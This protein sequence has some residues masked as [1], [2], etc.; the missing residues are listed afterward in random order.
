MAD[1]NEA[2][3]TEVAIIQEA[4]LDR[5]EDAAIMGVV[6]SGDKEAFVYE[7]QQGGKTIRGLTVAGID[8]AANFRGGITI[9]EPKIEEKD[10]S[11]FVMV[12]AVDEVNKT[13]RWGCFEQP[14]KQGSKHDIFAITKAVSKAQRNA[15]RKVLPQAWQLRAIAHLCGEGPMPAVPAM[16]AAAQREEMRVDE[17]DTGIDRRAT[18]AGLAELMPALGVQGITKEAVAQAFRNNFGVESRADLTEEN[19]AELAAKVQYAK[20]DAG[21]LSTLADWIK[22]APAPQPDAPA[23]EAG[24]PEEAAGIEF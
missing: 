6:T 4:D 7:F 2:T 9:T 22:P 20:T 14:K 10:N 8:E 1:T 18:M 21:G 15:L 12:E 3:G 17:P 11:Y 24:A 5:L 19:W 23:P 13:T 16:P